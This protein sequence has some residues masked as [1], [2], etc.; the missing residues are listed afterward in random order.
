MTTPEEELQAAVDRG[1]LQAKS[2]TAIR[3][4]LEQTERRWIVMQV[5]EIA[6]AQAL[7]PEQFKELCVWIREFTA[8]E[9]AQATSPTYG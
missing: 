3:R 8:T 6:V 1:E 7:S 2:T 4:Q 9:P 5:K